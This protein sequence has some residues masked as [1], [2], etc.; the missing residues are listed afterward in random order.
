MAVGSSGHKRYGPG[1]GKTGI[2]HFHEK[3]FKLEELL[4]GDAARRMAE[5]RESF[6]RTF[7]DQ[8]MRES[9]GVV[10]INFP[11]LPYHLLAP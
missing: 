9:G 11:N 1:A 8:F 3:L 2:G 7:L 6:M 5:E 4:N 10:P